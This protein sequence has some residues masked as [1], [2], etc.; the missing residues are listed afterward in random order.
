MPWS[1]NTQGMRRWLLVAALGAAL[2]SPLGWGQRRGGSSAGLGGHPSM[3]PRGGMGGFPHSAGL[4]HGPGM[5]MPATNSRWGVRIVTR[6]FP[7]TCFG[8]PC[9]N[10]WWAVGWYP[11]AGWW[12]GG[13]G[14]Y[15]NSSYPAPNYSPSD[16]GAETGRE[17]EQQAEI[18]RLREEVAGLREARASSPAPPSEAES[19]PTEL[20]FRDQHTEEVKNYAIMGQSL[21]VLTSGRSKK[22]PL[23]QLDLIATKKANEDNGVEFKIPR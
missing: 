10:R 5:R 8:R 13:P 18:D 1:Y 11:Y 19:E 14:W 23:S 21:W 4:P 12:Y 9:F 3:A 17:Q 16:S 2:L 20:I 22:I 6:P 15:D 7:N